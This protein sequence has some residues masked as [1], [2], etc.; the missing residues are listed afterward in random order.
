VTEEF[1]DRPDVGAAQLGGKRA[2]KSVAIYPL[3][4]TPLSPPAAPPTRAGETSWAAKPLEAWTLPEPAGP[5][6]SE[7]VA[8][9]GGSRAE[10]EGDALARSLDA[11]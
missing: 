10:S 9:K 3:F 5:S 4:D 6:E 2:A 8:E 7:G 11:S 1:L